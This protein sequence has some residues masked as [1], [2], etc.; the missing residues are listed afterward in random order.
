MARP[1]DFDEK[2]VLAKAVNLFWRK[3]YNGTSMDDLVETLGISRSS[4]YRTFVDKDILF[5][6]ALANY[7]QFSSAEIRSVINP[8][9]TA[10]K[11]VQKIMEFVADKVLSD[12]QKKGC[13]M[14]NSEVELGPHDKQIQ[15]MVLANDRETE[16]LIY[17]VL[18]KGR[19]N[20]EFKNL[21]DPRASSRFLLNNLKGIRVSAKSINDKAVFADII[22]LSISTLH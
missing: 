18:K 11:S 17:A 8:S 4:L 2:E 20:G 7:Q 9:D 3:G 12:R 15:K 14:V 6:R 5:K 19:D 22:K 10:R 13:F 21:A 1:R 16:D